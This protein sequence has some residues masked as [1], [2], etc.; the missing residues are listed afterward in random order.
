MSPPSNQRT[1]EYGGSFEN[2]IRLTLEVVD[3]TRKTVPKDMP[4]FLRISATDWLEKAEGIDGWTVGDTINHPK[5]QIKTG[6]GYQ[7]SVSFSSKKF[8]Q[9]LS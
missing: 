5:Q 3:L 2:R 4:V 9:F 1:D 7:V 6:P 8:L